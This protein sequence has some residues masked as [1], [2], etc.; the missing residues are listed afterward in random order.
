MRCLY[1]GNDVWWSQR[2]LARYTR[3]VLF[4]CGAQGRWTGPIQCVRFCVIEYSLGVSCVYVRADGFVNGEWSKGVRFFLVELLAVRFGGTSRGLR[5]C[6]CKCVLLSYACAVGWVR[7][8]FHDRGGGL[9]WTWFSLLLLCGIFVWFG[10][11]Q[12]GCLLCSV[13]K[14]GVRLRGWICC[15]VCIPE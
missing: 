13:P 14:E 4:L 9:G 10:G 5:K 11:S 7:H 12:N 8:V 3:Q 2:S 15:T 6:K 1:V